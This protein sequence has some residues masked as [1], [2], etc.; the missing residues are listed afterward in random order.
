MT[1]DF[2]IVHLD[3]EDAQSI[4]D[5]AVRAAGMVVLMDN[6]P[7]HTDTKSALERLDGYIEAVETMVENMPDCLVQPAIAVATEAYNEAV[8]EEEQVDQFREEL[9]DL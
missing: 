2:D 7:E 5:W 9:R 4:I 6:A 8:Y 3:Q 1:D